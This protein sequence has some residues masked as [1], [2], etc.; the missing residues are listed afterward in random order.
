MKQSNISTSKTA[1]II[2][3]RF[4]RCPCCDSTE[5][6]TIWHNST[7]EVIKDWKSFMFGN[8]RFFGQVMECKT[9]GFRYLEPIILG[10]NFYHIADHSEYRALRAARLH[11]FSKIKAIIHKRG[12]YL[13]SDAKIL[14]IGAGEGDWLS[15]W[16]EIKKRYGTELFPN[17]ISRMKAR[18]ISVLPTLDNTTKQFDMITAFDFLEHVENPNHL[19]Q[20]INARL[21]PDGMLIVGVPN[22]GKFLAR[23]FGTKYYLYCPMHFSYFTRNSLNKLLSRYFKKVDI[24]VS[25]PMY[26]TLNSV[27]KWVFPKLQFHILNHVWLPFGYSASLIAIAKE[28]S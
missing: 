10:D 21:N 26:C 9:C 24:F 17:F 6:H 28:P 20:M 12:H 3:E 1:P 2:I 19:L 8:R 25:P 23:L 13:T 18:G 27:L 7:P 15:I 22:M 14:D 5:L 16:S 4:E 11:Y